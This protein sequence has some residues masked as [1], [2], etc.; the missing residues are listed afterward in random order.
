MAVQ[1]IETERILL[2]P[3]DKIL[4]NKIQIADYSMFNDMGIIPAEG[5]PDEDVLDTLPRILINLEKVLSPTGFES[6]MVI[7]KEKNEIIGD[8][9][10][11]GR[12]D[13]LGRIDLGYGIVE[14]ARKKGY[15]REAAIGLINWAFKDVQVIEITAKCDVGNI[16]SINLLSSLNF[17]RKNTEENMIGWSLV[18][19]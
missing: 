8:I 13:S 2:I 17:E 16:G 1:Q 15:T 18:R 14:S 4:I 11:K 3:Y 7:V 10:F 19:N 12:P 5:W 6:W 9:G